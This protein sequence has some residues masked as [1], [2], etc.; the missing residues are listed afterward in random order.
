ME[1]QKITL[2]LKDFINLASGENYSDKYEMLGK[3][4]K[5][6]MLEYIKKTEQNINDN[7]SNIKEYLDSISDEFELSCAILIILDKSVEKCDDIDDVSNND[8]RDIYKKYKPIFE[9]IKKLNKYEK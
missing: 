7:I 6:Y 2:D 8:I 5:E 3:Y 1:L 9:L 4:S